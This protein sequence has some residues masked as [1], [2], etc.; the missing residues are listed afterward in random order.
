M[1]DLAGFLCTVATTSLPWIDT[2][3]LYERGLAERV[4]HALLFEILAIGISAPLAACLTVGVEPQR[5][6][7][8]SNNGF[9]TLLGTKALQNPLGTG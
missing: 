3:Q 7:S 9:F 1:D 2:M 5:E 6:R 8:L 4:L